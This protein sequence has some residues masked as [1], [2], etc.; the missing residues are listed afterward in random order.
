MRL[1]DALKQ[2]DWTK[3]ASDPSTNL[4]LRQHGLMALLA[5]LFAPT[6]FLVFPDVNPVILVWSGL[7]SG[8]VLGILPGLLWQMSDPE[9][10]AKV[11]GRHTIMT[12]LMAYGCFLPVVMF[13]AA[14]ASRDQK[15]IDHMKS[16]R[17]CGVRAVT[18]A[19]CGYHQALTDSAVVGSFMRLLADSDPFVRSHENDNL[20][21]TVTLVC[22]NGQFHEYRAGIPN[23][24][25]RDLVIHPGEAE[26][27]LRLGA[28]FVDSEFK[29]RSQCANCCAR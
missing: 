16:L 28:E 23:R 18:F 1:I 19:A 17:Q 10:R 26:M 9:R 29:S 2:L 14:N 5:A 4:T 24:H 12:L 11:N 21:F 8:V 13:N 20:S 22:A 7:M 15:E 27:L 6:W 25:P 3:P